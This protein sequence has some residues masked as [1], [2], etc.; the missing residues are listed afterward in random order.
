MGGSAAARRGVQVVSRLQA[1]ALVVP[2]SSPADGLR[3]PPEGFQFVMS[4]A[5]AVEGGV[6]AVNLNVLE[7]LAELA[8][9]SGCG[10]SV[11]SYRERDE[12]RPCTLPPEIGFRGFRHR[13]L[14]L[15]AAMLRG[16]S[17]RRLYLFD[18]LRLARPMLPLM[19]ARQARLVVFAHGWEYW[20]DLRPLDAVVLRR[21]RLCLANSHFTLG[22]M[23]ERMPGL[24]AQVCWLGLSP[25]FPLEREIRPGPG[26]PLWLQAVDGRRRRLGE[27]MLLMTARMEPAERL[28]GPHPLLRTLPR[29]LPGHPGLQLVLAGPGEERARLAR[30]AA[31]LGVAS[32]VFL[33]G[34]VPVPELARLYRRAYAFVMPSLQE[35]FGLAY[36]EAMNYGK[37]CLGCRDQGAEEVISEGETGV[38]VSDPWNPEELTAALDGLLDA[39][40]SARRMGEAGFRRLHA[41]FTAEHFRSRLRGVL[42]PLLEGSD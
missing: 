36:L 2:D 37:A 30:T 8:R 38:L 25:R 11:L 4:G 40:E 24:R 5:S 27:R 16:F 7:V 29:L 22:K 42:E 10:A 12:D 6:S 1:Q 15:A 32:A 31:Q 39:P 20:K 34:H 18:Y 19:L 28:K 3:V 35:G 33:P 14:G 21:A 9:Q 17:A 13:K 41:H 23:K 26:E